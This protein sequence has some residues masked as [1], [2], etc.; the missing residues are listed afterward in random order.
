MNAP[1]CIDKKLGT[2]FGQSGDVLRRWNVFAKARY[3][4]VANHLC[5]FRKYDALRAT[6]SDNEFIIRVNNNS[7]LVYAN[8]G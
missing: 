8:R 5:F 7:I 1:F 4:R 6:S 3:M 2:P